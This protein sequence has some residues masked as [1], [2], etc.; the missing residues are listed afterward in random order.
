MFDFNLLFFFSLFCV[1]IKKMLEKQKQISLYN[2]ICK[3]VCVNDDIQKAQATWA[4]G[5]W[6]RSKKK[7]KGMWITKGKQ[8][9]F[10]HLIFLS[11]LILLLLIIITWHWEKGAFFCLF[12]ALSDVFLC[13]QWHV[14]LTSKCLVSLSCSQASNKPP[15]LSD[16]LLE[17]FD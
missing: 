16:I 8:D 1:W 15:V 5:P 14:E 17:M 4:A 13:S 10:K 2:Y 6:I 12:P 9:V 11:V 7:K 3:C